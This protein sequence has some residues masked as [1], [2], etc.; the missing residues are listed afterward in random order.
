MRRQD[1]DEADG[2]FPTR[3]LSGGQEVTNVD[4][5]LTKNRSEGAF[6]HVAVV[7]RERD[8]PVRS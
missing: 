8:L 6:R 5:R 7:A 2:R 3:T 1:T 4:A